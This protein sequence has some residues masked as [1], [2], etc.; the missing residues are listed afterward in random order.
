MGSHRIRMYLERGDDAV[1]GLYYDVADWKPILLGGSW[2]D[3]GLTLQT[4]PE[5][6]APDT[7]HRLP[8][9]VLQGDP[10]RL[11]GEWVPVDKANLRVELQ[12][13][14]ER[15]CKGEGPW[16]TF[17]ATGWPFTF[18]SPASWRVVPHQDAREGSSTRWL[19]LMCPDPK[20][21]AYGEKIEI[22]R[23]WPGPDG[24]VSDFIRGSHGEWLYGPACDQPARKI[25]EGCYQPNLTT[26]QG[27][28][29]F[30][31][32]QGEWRTYCING[33]YRGAAEGHRYLLEMRNEWFQISGV[34]PVE[35]L[36][37]RL[38]VSLKPR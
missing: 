14:T 17:N 15:S 37:P 29:L 3:L 35:D 11:S 13:T 20:S 18:S 38:V 8:K 2:K 33:A 16:R 31:A 10:K 27:M 32:D 1:V 6:G 7:E 5:L 23:E 22:A 4:W 24:M 12:S 34:S 25:G 19:E 9:F 28:Q 26:R 30:A 21:M 36:V